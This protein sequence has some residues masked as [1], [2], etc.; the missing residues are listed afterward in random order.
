M[1]SSEY[2]LVITVIVSG[3]VIFIISKLTG[4]IKD[5]INRKKNIYNE[6]DFEQLA[7]TFVEFKKEGERRLQ[8]LEAII[9]EDEIELASSFE[10]PS[11]EAELDSM[12]EIDRGNNVEEQNK[13]SKGGSFRNTNRE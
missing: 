1:T 2:D 12:I 5:W 13:S 6:E 7:K 10:Q 11:E 4:L 9:S 8:N 3:V